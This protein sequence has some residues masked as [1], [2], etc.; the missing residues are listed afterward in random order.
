M[1]K[2]GRLTPLLMVC[3]GSISEAGPGL[4]QKLIENSSRRSSFAED[5]VPL[6]GSSA[7]QPTSPLQCSVSR[8]HGRMVQALALCNLQLSP[9]SSRISLD[10]QG[11]SLKGENP[12]RAP[13]HGRITG[14]R[15]PVPWLGPIDRRR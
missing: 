14:R 15:R 7:P 1:R 8:A 11:C 2:E 4:A 5:K 12:R 6:T 9:E 13:L 10:R 3:S